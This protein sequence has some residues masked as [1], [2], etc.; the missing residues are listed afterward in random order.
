MKLIEVTL[1]G[2]LEYKH[3][4]PHE[5]VPYWNY[6]DE[7]YV[8]NGVIYKNHKVIIPKAMRK[9]MLNKIHEGHLGEV[10]C[11]SRARQVLFWPQMTKDIENVVKTC[12]A[13][14]TYRNK[15]QT[16]PLI[17]I[18]VSEKPWSLVASDLFEYNRKH[19]LLCVDAYSNFPEVEEITSQNSTAVIK[20]MKHIFSRQGKP[21]ILYSDNG[22]CYSSEEFKKFT[23]S[24]EFEHRTSSPRYPQSNGLAEKYVQ[25]VKNIFRKC[26]YSGEDREMGLLNYRSTPLDS[27]LSPAELMGRVIK[28]NLPFTLPSK[29]R[30]SRKIV[31]HKKGQKN[32]QKYYHDKRAKS[33][34]TLNIG[35]AV[36]V[37][38]ESKSEWKDKGVI[39][40]KVAPRSYLVE[41]ERGSVLRRNRKLVRNKGK[42]YCKITRSREYHNTHK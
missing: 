35:N 18:P 25:I 30:Y 14:L 6:R 16:E 19:Y 40:S 23:K 34:S 20:A 41:T 22:P 21:D 10:K 31:N 13:C 15:Q 1:N 4:C 32:R 7:L 29:S 26:D 33:L 42:P 12:K 39:L 36:G 11:K 38:D 17:S 28:S 9:E 8:I 24:W 37:R 5:I 3:E 2:W 27:G